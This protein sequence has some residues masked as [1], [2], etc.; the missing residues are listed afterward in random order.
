MDLWKPSTNWGQGGPLIEKY[1][2]S[3]LE[4]GI[5]WVAQCRGGETEHA[6]CP[7][8]S[9]CRAIVQSKIGDVV[10][11]PDYLVES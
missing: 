8:V 4:Q 6:E 9:I 2:V 1:R 10:E 5:D 11:V 3:I 7:L